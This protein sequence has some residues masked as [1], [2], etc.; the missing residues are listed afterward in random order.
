M[1]RDILIKEVVMLKSHVDRGLS[2][3]PSY[4]LKGM[5]F[6]YKLQLHHILPNSFTII[7]GFVALCEGYLGVP[8]MEIC[9]IYTSTSAR[10]RNQT[11]NF[12]TAA[13]FPSSLAV[14]KHIHISSHMIPPG[15]GGEPSITKLIKRPL[16]RSSGSG[17]LSIA[18]LRSKISRA[19]WMIP[20]WM[21]NAN[22]SHGGLPNF[23]MMD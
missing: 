12:A 21:R 13:P 6:H 7:A 22:F 17:L 8:P 3:W 9:S 2:L 1:A 15:D 23:A 20:P 14:G 5:L 11:E 16:T 10:T 4:F 19:S 18:P